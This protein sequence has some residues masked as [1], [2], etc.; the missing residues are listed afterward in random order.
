MFA[1]HRSVNASFLVARLEGEGEGSSRSRHY[2]R[3]KKERVSIKLTVTAEAL[4]FPTA[5]LPD[6]YLG[7]RA[8]HWFATSNNRGLIRRQVLFGG[9]EGGCDVFKRLSTC[10]RRVP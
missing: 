2:A 6:N 3:L 4:R 5:L 10:S 8:V 9:G 7:F 1:F